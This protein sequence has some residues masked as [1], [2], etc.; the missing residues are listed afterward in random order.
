MEDVLALEDVLDD[1]GALDGPRLSGSLLPVTDLV[2][3]LVGAG[4]EVEGVT[5]DEEEAPVAFSVAKVAG[6]LDHCIEHGLEVRR[7]AAP[8]RAH[9][10]KRG[11]AL[12]RLRGLPRLL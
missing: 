2:G 6:Q 9:P 4:P 12:P 3:R 11:R 1:V 5:V 8:A 7:G 10:R